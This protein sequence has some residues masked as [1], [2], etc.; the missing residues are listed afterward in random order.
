[1]QLSKLE[2]TIL[3][4]RLEVPECITEVLAD[5]MGCSPETLRDRVERICDLLTAGSFDEAMDDELA[6]LVLAEA[7][8]G[9]TF[10]G[11]ADGNVSD[12]TMRMY[13]KASLSL[14]DK[15]REFTSL[16]CNPPLC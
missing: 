7:V 6:G 12:R 5:D 1:M 14:A 8:D 13:V 16:D 4:H 10:I 15:V 3:N 9:S 11:A 2:R